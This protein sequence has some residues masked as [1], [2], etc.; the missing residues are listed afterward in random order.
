MRSPARSPSPTKDIV[1]VKVHDVM[2]QN[3]SRTK[4]A[5]SRSR[6]AKKE[7]PNTEN[8]V[9]QGLAERSD[10]NASTLSRSML[11]SRASNPTKYTLKNGS[12]TL[13]GSQSPERGSSP[14][15]K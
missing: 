9:L 15:P 13:V 11:K 5:L 7:P 3:K 4:V 6:N 2:V 12:P 14:E 10:L 1:L 8:K